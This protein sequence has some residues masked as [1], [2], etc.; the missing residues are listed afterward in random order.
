MGSCPKTLIFALAATHR[1]QSSLTEPSKIK[2]L[3]HDPVQ[4]AWPPRL[5]ARTQRERPLDEDRL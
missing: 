4:S 5:C 1:Y 2:P 3:G